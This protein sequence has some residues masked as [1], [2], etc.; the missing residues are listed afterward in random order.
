MT[1]RMLTSVG[2]SPSYAFGE[3]VEVSDEVAAAWIRDGLAERAER[4]ETAE[5]RRPIESAVRAGRRR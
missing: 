3:I 5:Q 4:V 2:G 1:I